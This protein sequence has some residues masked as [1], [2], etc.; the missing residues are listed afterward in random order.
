M[1]DTQTTGNATPTTTS[2]Y[3]PALDQ[4]QG[5]GGMGMGGFSPFGQPKN[6]IIIDTVNQLRDKVIEL[7][8]KIQALLL[9]IRKV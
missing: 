1:S 4:N 2:Q 8:G 6:E 7:D 3:P 5:M 9:V